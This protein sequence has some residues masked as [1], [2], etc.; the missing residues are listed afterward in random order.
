MLLI[1]Q[2]IH[3]Y[4]GKSHILQGVSM[5]V[6]EKEIIALLGRNGVGKSTTLKSIIGINPPERGHIYFHD[7]DKEIDITRMLP[8]K[9]AQLGIGY[10]PEDRRI[11]T[12]LTVL[13]NLRTGLDITHK[14]KRSREG[15]LEE[16][17]ACFPVLG[18]RLGQAGRTLSGGE[19]QMLAIARVMVT[20]PKLVLMDEPSEGIM[21][22][23]VEEIKEAIKR[24]RDEGISVLLVEQNS[25]MALDISKKAYI[26]EKGIVRYEGDATELAENREILSNYLGVS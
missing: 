4:Y 13:E 16:A 1:A 3:T 12:H 9:T 11:F 25:E 7:G 21:P 8:Y 15:A 14:D 5:E 10:V 18:K 19:Q 20:R 23:L 6:K 24:M 22:I 26:M 17:F 2:D